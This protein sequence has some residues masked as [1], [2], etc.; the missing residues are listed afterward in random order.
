MATLK[1]GM[2]GPE[3]VKLQQTINKIFRASVVP[4]SGDY[5]DATRDKVA[6]LQN[7][8]GV[9]YTSGIADAKT[10]S[11]FAFAL[12][13]K[14]LVDLHA[15][16]AYLTAKELAEVRKYVRAEVV[17]AMQPM[18][19]L[20]EKFADARR[21]LDDAR[22]D[23][24]FW[25][26][27]LDIVTGAR[28]PDEGQARKVK[29]AA[30][31][32]RSEAANGTLTVAGF[33]KYAE[34]IRQ[35][36]ADL[37]Q[38]R[39]E[40]FAG[41]E[42]FVKYMEKTSEACVV[43]VEVLMAIETG[44]SSVQVQVGGAAAAAGYKALIGEVKTASKTAD[45]SKAAGVGRV[46]LA[47]AVGG[48]VKYVMKGARGEDYLDE[49]AKR[50]LQAAG[51]GFLKTFIVT[52][53]RGGAG[54]MIEDGLNGLPGLADPS[55]KLTWQDVVVAGATSFIDGA[56]LKQLGPVCEKWSKSGSKILAQEY[57][58]LGKNVKLDKAAENGIKKA[59]D[60]ATKKAIEAAVDNLKPGDKPDKLDAEIRKEI[61]SDSDVKDAIEDARKGN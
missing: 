6:D 11:E 54:K 30:E 1:P 13:P 4:E 48:G 10:L 50:A 23:N 40:T 29:D 7:R 52:S 49:V 37:D 45:Y 35:A 38:Y 16:E 57:F 36:Y 42:Q 5:D 33:Q 15:V 56:F 39:D 55:K 53:V 20:A 9:G 17:Q 44:G 22:A 31:S 2:S 60:K 47:A 14:F 21:A 25:A 59:I 3:V 18:L 19:N 43:A 26:N 24:W 32:I 28:L 61:L 51:S 34:V 46:F 8:L 41:G 27:V 12:T 58:T